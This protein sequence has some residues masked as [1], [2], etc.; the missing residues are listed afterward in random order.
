MTNGMIYKD[1]LIKDIE[2][3]NEIIAEIEFAA[4]VEEDNTIKSGLSSALGQLKAAR[5]WLI[6]ILKGLP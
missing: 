2:R 6:K 5:G 4:A 3:T 1:R